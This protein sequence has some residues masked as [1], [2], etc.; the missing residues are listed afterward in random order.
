MLVPPGESVQRTCGEEAAVSAMGERFLILEETADAL[1]VIDP[2]L[3]VQFRL[4]N[5]L[6]RQPRE[7]L[8]AALAVSGPETSTSLPN[9][10]E[11]RM[12]VGTAQISSGCSCGEWTSAVA[13]DEVDTMVIRI[14]EHLGSVP[15]STEDGITETVSPNAPSGAEQQVG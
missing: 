5:G 2:E 4:V 7:E 12:D 3:A 10:H 14:R 11:I 8:S 15:A 6:P 9:R 1:D 13:W